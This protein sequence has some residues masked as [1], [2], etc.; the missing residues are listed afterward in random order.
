MAFDLHYS[1][2]K[3]TP[4]FFRAPFNVLELFLVVLSSVSCSQV[5]QPLIVPFISL[6]PTVNL[7]Y[8]YLFQLP[9]LLKLPI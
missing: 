3:V 6:D 9:E 4:L 5:F 7:I 2:N 8:Y 1:Q